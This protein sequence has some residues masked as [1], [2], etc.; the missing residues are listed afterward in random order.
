[1]VTLLSYGMLI[2][3][4]VSFLMKCLIRVVNPKGNQSYIIYLTC[5]VKLSHFF[6]VGSS[7]IFT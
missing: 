7:T 2:F 6:S 4:L 5:F 3:V 1:M